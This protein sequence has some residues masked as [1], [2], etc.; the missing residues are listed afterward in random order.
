MRRVSRNGTGPVFGILVAAGRSERMEGIDKV[1][2]PLM[3]RPLVVWPLTAFKK[4]DDVDA[5][6][7]V[8]ADVGRMR[9]LVRE[10]R[11]DKV[12]DVVAGGETR[13]ESVRAGLEAARDAGIVVVHDAARPL[14]TPEIIADGIAIARETGAAICAVP[15]TDTVKQV[16]GDPPVVQAT[17]DRSGLWLAQTPQVFDR[18][19]LLDAHQRATD[20]ATDDSALV[21]ATGHAV[22]VYR[23]TSWN[24]KVTT[25]DDVIVAEALLR[26]RFSAPA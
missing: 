11:F 5:V 25:P 18:A 15:A 10:W 13:Q 21:E 14:V 12:S 8:A 16:A 2:V 23:G 24:I 3:G 1:F 6:I 17:P 20:V 9:A 7:V 4:C 19:L 22:R 26:E